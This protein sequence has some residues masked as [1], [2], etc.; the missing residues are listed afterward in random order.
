MLRPR[1]QLSFSSFADCAVRTVRGDPR[2]VLLA[3]RGKV[4]QERLRQHDHHHHRLRHC[5]SE[6]P[7]KLIWQKV[8]NYARLENADFVKVGMGGYEEDALM[9]NDL[10]DVYGTLNLFKISD[11]ANQILKQF[12]ALYLVRRSTF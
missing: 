2:H 6:P 4:R 12:L 7:P 8:V 3:N 5:E 10:K 1:H 9:E 11:R